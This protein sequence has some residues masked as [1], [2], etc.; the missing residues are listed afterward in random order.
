MRRSAIALA[1]ISAVITLATVAGCAVII[2]PE[3]GSVQYKSLGGSGIQ[4]NGQHV[5][6]RRDAKVV[7]AAG[8]DSIDSIDINGPMEVEVR[9][10][11]TP[12]LQVE[13]DSNL[14][15]LLHTDVSGGT[16]RVWVEGNLRSSNP[17]RVVYTTARLRD[18][19]TN[20][21]GRLSVTGLN[22]GSLSLS[23]NGSRSVRLTG[24]VGRLEVRSN[25]SGSIDA[26]G[27]QSGSTLA[28]SNGSGRLDL[29]RLQG[30][31]LSV[32]LRGSGGVNASGSVRDMNVRLF[33]SGSADLARLTCQSADLATY[34]S[35][36][37]SAAVSQ[38]LVANASGS[39]RVTVYGNPA[40]RSVSGKNVSVLQ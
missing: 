4:G 33:G 32:D 39:G 30:E 21:S 38:S 10:G 2:I 18:I 9:V 24:N 6:E 26:A 29:G 17:L 23:Q 1:T 20:G 13:G 34:G 14:L 27:L 40:Q 37:I 11:E 25:G 36:S 15:P 5:V 8:I 22:G 31:S 7:A 12:S 3:D 35:G 16:M 28:S 19:H